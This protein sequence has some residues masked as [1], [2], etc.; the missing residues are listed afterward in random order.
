MGPRGERF[1]FHIEQTLTPDA[2]APTNLLLSHFQQYAWGN[3]SNHNEK[4]TRPT[5][6]KFVV[7]ERWQLTVKCKR[8]HT[9]YN[10]NGYDFEAWALAHQIR[11]M[12]SIRSKSG[13][14]K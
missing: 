5:L 9:T 3:K 14:K 1:L 8:P 10:P 2:K 11:A 7:G 6:A 4:H 13:M 12:G